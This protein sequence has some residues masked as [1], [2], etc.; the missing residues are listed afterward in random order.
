MEEGRA[1]ALPSTRSPLS[2]IDALAGLAARHDVRL[3]LRIPDLRCRVVA[4]AVHVAVDRVADEFVRVFLLE[5]V[6]VRQRDGTANVV[7]EEPHPE[8]L[9]AVDNGPAA[10]EIVL[11]RV[12][13]DVERPTE[14]TLSA[15]DPKAAVDRR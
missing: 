14:R 10:D 15:V 7:P 6:V 8:S 5:Q 13:R 12:P 9:V 4:R 3:T 11:D 2:E 1:L